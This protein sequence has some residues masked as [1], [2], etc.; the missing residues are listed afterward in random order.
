MCFIAAILYNEHEAMRNLRNSNYIETRFIQ[1]SFRFLVWNCGISNVVLVVYEIFD[2][3]FA[4]NYFSILAWS[5]TTASI[6]SVTNSFVFN[7]NGLFGRNLI[8]VAHGAITDY[9]HL[10]IDSFGVLG[11][12]NP[13]SLTGFTTSSEEKLEAVSL[14]LQ[15]SKDGSNSLRTI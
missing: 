15:E 11:W 6:S 13:G 5:E 4:Q 3:I 2:R 14:S 8:L 10:P 1:V 12:F 7:C 9:V